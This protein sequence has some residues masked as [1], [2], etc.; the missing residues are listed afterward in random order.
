MSTDPQPRGVIERENVYA[1]RV[2]A[3]LFAAAEPL[4][5]ADIRSYAGDGD[6]G[7]A[8]DRLAR[9]Y[10]ARGVNLV[11]RGGR[12]HFQTAPDCAHLLATTR[13]IPRRLSRAALE[14]LAIIAY[15]EPVTRAGIEEIRG[16]QVS[17]GTLDTLMETGWIRPAGRKE[18]PGRP[19]QYA[20]TA[21]FLAHFGLA[22]RRDLPG[23]ADLRAAGLLEA[24]SPHDSPA[25]LAP[26][27]DCA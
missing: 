25:A 15:H 1:R 17:G 27:P 2:E 22:S 23:L 26:A 19:L 6:L 21:D 24:G 3:V 20:T 11:E 18:S 13:D 14:T 8:L 10:A 9:D 16:V 4:S 12:W 5:P 7:A